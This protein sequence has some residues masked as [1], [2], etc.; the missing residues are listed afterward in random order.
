MFD[1]VGLGCGCFD[2]IGIVPHIPTVDEEIQML[3][4]SQQGGGEVATALVALSNLGTT[5]AY[6]GKIGDD[7]IGTIIKADLEDSGVDTSNLFVDKGATS[8]ASVVLV[9]K[10]SGK[11]TISICVPTYADVR[12]EEVNPELVSSAKA[13][14]VD[15][16]FRAAA[17]EAAR[18]AQAAGVTVV[19]DADV[20]GYDEQIGELIALTDVL[21]PSKAFSSLHTKQDDPERA[22]QAFLEEGPS[23]VVQTLGSE[24]SLC[25]HDGNMFRSP[26]FQVDVVDTTGAGDVFHGA[27]IHGMLQDWSLP[28]T[29]EFASAVAAIKCTKLGGRAGI[30][31]YDEA[32]AFMRQH[33][34]SWG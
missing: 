27:F 24:G 30:P 1:V 2:F 23:T 20:Q 26:A 12:P 29:V 3:E 21:I 5:T 31:T 32:D 11:R 22:V 13:L 33:D 4:T 9:D 28:K 14:L 34:S 10:E 18:I 8:L 15:C 7:P 25:Y 16:T 19:L 6:I 17:L